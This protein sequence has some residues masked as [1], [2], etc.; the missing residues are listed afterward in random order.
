MIAYFF[1]SCPNKSFHVIGINSID[2]LFFALSFLFAF[3]TSI[4]IF[5]NEFALF[6]KSN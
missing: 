2:S 5:L 4:D 1:E 3:N 6:E